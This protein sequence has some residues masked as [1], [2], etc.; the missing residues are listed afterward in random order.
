VVLVEDLPRALEVEVVLGGL[1]P[2][3][4]ENPVKVCADHAVL[5]RGR[6][7]PLQASELAVDSLANFLGQLDLLD[8][9]LELLELSLLGIAF[10][11]LLLNR[12]QLLAQEVL[13][14]ALLHLGLD[15]RLNLGSELEDLELAVEDDG[16][17]AQ[18]AL[19]VGLLEELLALLRLQPQRGGNEV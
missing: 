19:D 3:Q 4:R 9:G 1:R 12:L 7:Q 16:E 11:E 15:L 17:L 10:T 8:A 14:L 2:R 13:A 18:T 5:R 6:R